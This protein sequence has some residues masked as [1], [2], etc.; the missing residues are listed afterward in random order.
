MTPPT[1]L[2]ALGRRR[3]HAHQL[4]MI[5]PA[6]VAL[7]VLGCITTVPRQGISGSVSWEVVDETVTLRETAGIGIEFSSFKYS[8]PI[9]PTGGGKEY[10]GGVGEVKFLRRLEPLA[11][12][13]VSLPWA[14]R[15]G[16]AEYEFRGIDD[17]GRPVNVKVP[18]Q[19][20][21]PWR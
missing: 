4:G 3:F 1:W 19:L 15:G 12:V 10:F 20:Q 16:V 17:N 21:R 18:V 13:R 2:D 6:L 14:Y 5:V 9:P 11:A 8:V 7:L